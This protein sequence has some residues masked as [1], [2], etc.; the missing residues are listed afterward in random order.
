VEAAYRDE[1]VPLWVA[2]ADGAVCGF[3]AARL[4]HEASMGEIYLIAVD[5]EHQRLGIGSALTSVALDWVKQN[6][7]AA[8][9]VETGGDPGHAPARAVYEKAGF[10]QL[11]VARY[12]KKL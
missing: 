1:N 7:M 12:F 10:V 3:V 9:M 8:A 6:G 4:D 5:P 2:D 11:P